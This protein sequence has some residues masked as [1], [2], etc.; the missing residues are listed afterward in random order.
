LIS[1]DEMSVEER[2]LSRDVDAFARRLDAWDQ[3]AAHTDT[4]DPSSAV[5]SR[6]YVAPTHSAVPPEVA[7]LEA[8]EQ[9]HGGVTG[10]WHPGDHAD[11][12][13]GRVLPHISAAEL[14]AHTAWHRT[15]EVLVAAR[16]DALARWRAARDDERR[17]A[18]AAA[19]AAAEA[20]AA[21]ES[22]RAVVSEAERARLK[23]TLS[24]WKAE[25]RWSARPDD[26]RLA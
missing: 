18:A 25:V 20:A 11:F 1:F 24:E 21:L 13:A 7:A 16:R 23:S 19:A 17:A 3:P 5:P 26:A 22:Q 8:F 9:Q 4:A 10:G 15:H 12:V 6:L 2:S 14:A